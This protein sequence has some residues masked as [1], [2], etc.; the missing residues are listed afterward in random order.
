MH[1]VRSSSQGN[2]PP[3]QGWRYRVRALEQH[4]KP[5]PLCECAFRHEARLGFLFIHKLSSETYAE[6]SGRIEVAYAKFERITPDRQTAVERG[7]DPSLFA[8]LSTLPFND[9][10][11][12]ALTTQS[13]HTL[14]KANEAC[15]RLDTGQ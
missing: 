3:P 8:L 12:Q 14:A 9:H 7:E 11:R 5:T 15:V 6:Y 10:I 1:R 13:G 2:P 4:R